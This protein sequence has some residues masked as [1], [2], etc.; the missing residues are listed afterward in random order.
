MSLKAVVD[1]LDDI[2]S[3]FHELYTEKNGK[4]ELTG[5]EGVKTQ[6]DVDRLQSALVKERQDH[7]AVRERMSLLGDRKIEDVLSQLDRIPEL[8]QAAHGKVDDNQL[9]KLVESRIRTKLAPIERERDAFKAKA[10]EQE[11]LIEN[12][13]KKER[14]R[15]VHDEVR[16]AARKSKV[17]PEALEDALMLAERV[18]EIDEDGKVVTRDGVGVTPGV[19]ASVWFT[20]LQSKRPHWWGTS[21]GGGA[22]GSRSSVSSANNPW[23]AQNWNMTEQGRI[24]TE[25]PKRAEQL[26][27]SAG[28]SV[29]GLRPKAK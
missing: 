4:F 3:K 6:A 8:E 24:Y 7:K 19:D 20:E 13:T 2:D 11:M 15:S 12:F 5:I 28:T 23:S 18:F 17:I 1:T 29:G 27:R 9:E 16:S 25:N 21:V 26:A 22:G 14:T 10:T